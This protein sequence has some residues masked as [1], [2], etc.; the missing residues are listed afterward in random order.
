MNLKDNQEEVLIEDTRE[1][2]NY[3]SGIPWTLSYS[4]RYGLIAFWRQS[5]SRV[6]LDGKSLP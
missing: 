2:P 6:K 4:N 5:L 1:L 3:A